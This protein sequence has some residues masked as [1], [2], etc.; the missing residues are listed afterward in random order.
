MFGF[1]VNTLNNNKGF[2][3]IE[4]LIALVIMTG[5]VTVVAMAWSGS[6]QRLK[7]MKINHQLAFLLDYKVSDIER[8]Y[9]LILTQLPDA[10]QGTFEELSPEYKDYSWTLQSKK[11][12]LPD[13]TPL[14][15]SQ[16]GKDTFDPMITMMMD[17][18]SE[19]FNQAAKEVTVTITYTYKKNKIQY[20]ASKFLIDFNQPLPMGAAAGMVPPAG[21]SQ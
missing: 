10:E 11:F 18:L 8:K 19:F 9:R 12:E 4:V 6:Q 16:G 13:L 14:M 2:S 7:K 5:S 20:A 17:S 1:R 21:Q 15:V 3:L